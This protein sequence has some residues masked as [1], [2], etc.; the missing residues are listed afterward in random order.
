VSYE[1]FWSRDEVEIR[2]IAWVFRILIRIE[3]IYD[4]CRTD[5]EMMMATKRSVDFRFYICFYFEF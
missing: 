5:L 4:D 2:C 3:L 1:V